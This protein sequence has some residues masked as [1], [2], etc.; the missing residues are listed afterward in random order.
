MERIEFKPYYNELLR[1]KPFGTVI[2][3]PRSQ[4]FRL[5][6]VRKWG[7]WKP[8]VEREIG[9]CK[10]CRIRHAIATNREFGIRQCPIW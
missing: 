1:D 8:A 2:A 5:R 10:L 9:E 3:S 6:V 7:A 4:A